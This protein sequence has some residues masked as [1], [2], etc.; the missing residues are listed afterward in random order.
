MSNSA[1]LAAAKNRRSRQPNAQFKQDEQY[2]ENISIKEGK[3]VK[4]LEL[5]KNHDY[6]IF[7]L[8][9]NPSTNTNSVS[10]S[11]SNLESEYVT[12]KEFEL[13]QL[14]NSNTS[15]SDNKI[16]NTVD[17]HTNEISTLKTT[18]LQLNKNLNDANSLIMTMRA[19]L[20]SQ[21]NDINQLR[22]EFGEIIQQFTNTEEGT[23]D[24]V[25]VDNVIVD[26]VIVD[27]VIVDS[28]HVLQ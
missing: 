17:S 26:N 3:P 5:L 11:N 7:C 22:S 8:E 2:N 15:K 20:L 9:K 21:A 10:N 12:K 13:L 28:E 25:T 24:N 18:V 16:T 14:T 23:V 27:N 19:S 4:P 1:S 6:R